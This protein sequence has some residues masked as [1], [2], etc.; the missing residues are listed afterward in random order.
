MC[1]YTCEIEDAVCRMLFEISEHLAHSGSWD[2][3]MKCTE[4]DLSGK[5]IVCVVL[6]SNEGYTL[7]AN[8]SKLCFEHDM[9]DR[10]ECQRSSGLHW[11]MSA[12]PSVHT[13]SHA[14]TTQPSLNLWTSSSWD[15]RELRNSDQSTWTNPERCSHIQKDMLLVG[16]DEHARHVHLKPFFDGQQGTDHHPLRDCNNICRKMH[17]GQ[18]SV[19]AWCDSPTQCAQACLL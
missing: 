8:S 18:L 4:E 19:T 11:Q 7:N 17:M 10:K 14:G 13:A 3:T 12:F 5:G 6:R 9:L 15:T 16:C 2:C 1:M